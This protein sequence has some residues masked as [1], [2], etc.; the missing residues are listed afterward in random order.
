MGAWLTAP[1]LNLRLPAL[2][3]ERDGV[4]ELEED[5]LGAFFV[6]LG[7]DAL[8]A[9]GGVT[10]VAIPAGTLR[11]ACRVCPTAGIAG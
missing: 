7:V 2:E 10:V 8:P 3:E 5:R 4:A 11:A 1:V 6:P 9:A